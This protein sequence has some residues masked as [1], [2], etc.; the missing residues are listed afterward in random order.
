MTTHAEKRKM[1]YTQEQLFGLVADVAKYPEFLPWCIS[2]RINRREGNVFY[3]D[4][5]IGYK[6]IR[7]RFGS[8][9][10]LNEPGHI[11]VEYLS[12]PMKYL[13]N[14]WNFIE[15]DDG[16]C[17]ID[18]FVDFEFKNR[19]L[20]NLIGVFFNEV[21]QRMVGSFEARAKELYGTD[22]AATNDGSIS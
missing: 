20:Q 15:E 14:H 22:Q 10:T 16:T 2:S 6:L 9:V 8:K 11:H 1:P 12:G 17:T 21:V 3:A 19:V 5:S 7:E 13:S 4:L 18:F